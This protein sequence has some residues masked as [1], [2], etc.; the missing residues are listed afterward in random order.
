MGEQQ[1][2]PV[3]GGWGSRSPVCGEAAGLAVLT[4][5]MQGWFAPQQQV[6]AVTKLRS[7]VEVEFSGFLTL[8]YPS[9]PQVLSEGCQGGSPG[10]EHAVAV[11]RP[12]EHLQKGKL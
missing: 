8:P 7:T 3:A 5:L 9:P 2:A 6:Q 1:E 11:P 4:L 12:P 10:A